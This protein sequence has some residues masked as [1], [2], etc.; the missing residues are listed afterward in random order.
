MKKGFMVSYQGLVVAYWE[1]LIKKMKGSKKMI[2]ERHCWFRTKTFVKN[3]F[4]EQDYLWGVYKLRI[5]NF[6]SYLFRHLSMRKYRLSSDF[7]SYNTMLNINTSFTSFIWVY[8]SL[9]PKPQ[10]HECRC[11]ELFTFTWK[12]W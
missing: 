5:K 12:T 8:H 4:V 7:S 6:H 10:V 1:L 2:E 3:H 11:D 9:S